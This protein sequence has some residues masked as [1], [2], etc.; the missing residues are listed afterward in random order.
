MDVVEAFRDRDTRDELGIGV[1]RDAIADTLFPGTTTLMTRARYYLFGPWIYRRLETN[2]TRSADVE[3]TD[4]NRQVALISALL[5][6]GESE[7]VIGRDRRERLLRLPSSIYWQGVGVWGI[8]AYP[9]SQSSYFR[10]LDSYYRALDS[11]PEHSGD[12]DAGPAVSPNWHPSMPGPPSGFPTGATLQLQRCEAEYLKDRLRSRVGD[13]LMAWLV[14]NS[15]E[16]ATDVPYA[17]RHPLFEE[18]RDTH[19][20]QLVHARNF[21]EAIWGAPLL[22]NLMLAEKHPDAAENG[23]LED[24]QKRWAE[25]VA[26]M[27]DGAARL[28]AWDLHD[29]WALADGAAPQMRPQ[30]RR[31]I[32]TWLEG[33]RSDPESMAHGDRG[34]ALVRRREEALKGPLARLSNRTALNM[35]GG[36]SGS[37]QLDFRWGTAQV[38]IDDIIVGLKATDDARA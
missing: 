1:I 13:S 29:F 17:W 23:W 7:G 2:R 10:S 4:R 32:D 35:W 27:H 8:R 12:E 6:S 24:Y 19:K 25:W 11:A 20:R 5:A 9:D 31:F 26:L 14:T 15:V 30:T 3:S 28:Q 18:F 37:Q 21:S 38:I 16:P 34:R 33:A 36:S 22:Y